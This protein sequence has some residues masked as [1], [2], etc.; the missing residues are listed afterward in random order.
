MNLGK[1]LFAQLMEFV[2]HSEKPFLNV[3]TVDN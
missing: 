3:M 1:T 2:P